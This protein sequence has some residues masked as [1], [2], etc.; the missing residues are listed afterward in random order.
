[1]TVVE[2]EIKF[3][4]LAKYAPI[5]VLIEREMVKR[6]IGGLNTYTPKDMASHVEDK[7]FLHGWICPNTRKVLIELS[8]RPGS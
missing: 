5:L 8:E 3:N 2:Y 6:F 7:S 1:M 4:R